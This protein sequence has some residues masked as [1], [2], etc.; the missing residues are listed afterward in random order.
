MLS[1]SNYSYSRN[2][3]VRDSLIFSTNSGVSML[4]LRFY[5]CKFWM[6]A[7][8]SSTPSSR[9]CWPFPRFPHTQTPFTDHLYGNRNFTKCL[10]LWRKFRCSNNLGTNLP[11][12]W[13][14]LL[15]PNAPLK[16][17]L[18]L[19]FLGKIPCYFNYSSYDTAFHLGVF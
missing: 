8:F 4:W 1:Y 3:R 11:Q 14:T 5:T 13:S 15:P 9:Q 16:Q 19:F 12:Q 2:F 17:V 7:P 18:L 10:G 6:V